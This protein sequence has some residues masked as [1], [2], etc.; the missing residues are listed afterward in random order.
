MT[1]TLSDIAKAKAE[2]LLAGAKP[3]DLLEALAVIERQKQIILAQ[4]RHAAWSTGRRGDGRACAAGFTDTMT[5]LLRRFASCGVVTHEEFE[6]LHRQVSLLR[7]RLKDKAPAVVIKTLAKI[8]YEITA[9]FDD[10]FRLLHADAKASL[11]VADFTPKQSVILRTL[12]ERGSIHV[13]HSAAIQRHMSNV[14]AKLAKHGLGKRIT[15][16]THAGDGLYT[17][18]EKSRAV[19]ASFVA[20]EI[21]PEPHSKPKPSKKQKRKAKKF[22]KRLARTTRAPAIGIAA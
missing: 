13:E 12:A 18:D 17:V 5:Q 21:A 8:G 11:C 4:D 22:A 1:L 6:D 7:K 10:V 2:V 16:E 20:G 3:K 15:I 19:L 14:R 9:G